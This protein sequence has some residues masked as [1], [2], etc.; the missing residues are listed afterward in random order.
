M[1]LQR[2][3]EADHRF[4]TPEAPEAPKHTVERTRPMGWLRKRT[5]VIRAESWERCFRGVLGDSAGSA[6][7]KV[8]Y[9]VAIARIFRVGIGEETATFAASGGCSLLACRNKEERD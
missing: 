4:A 7:E 2:E 1:L 6:P 9:P 5:P 8:V 3:V